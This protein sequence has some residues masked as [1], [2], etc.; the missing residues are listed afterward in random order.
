MS[1]TKR[2]SINKEEFIRLI[3]R[4]AG[5]TLAD[6][7]IFW[8]T[9][10]QIFAR[11]IVSHKTVTITGFGKLYI[12]DIPGTK[13]SGNKFWDNIHKKYYERKASKR[14]VFQVSSTLRNLLKDSLEVELDEELI[15]ENEVD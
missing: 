2:N 15:S 1:P 10:E 4:E 6:T 11:A 9:V 3:A 5:F 7:R 14:V 12:V 8:D 13:E